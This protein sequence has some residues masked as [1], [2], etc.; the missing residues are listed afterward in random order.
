MPVGL[1]QPNITQLVTKDKQCVDSNRLVDVTI[2]RSRIFSLSLILLPKK[3]SY[4]W[5]PVKYRK[6]PCLQVYFLLPQ[7]GSTQT[8]HRMN[9]KN[10]ERRPKT[11]RFGQLTTGSTEVV[12]QEPLLVT[13][14]PNL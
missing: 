9:A 7:P 14:T 13:Y 8:L 5:S 4:P 11:M 1:V 6:Q 12:E 10:D 3:P 2:T